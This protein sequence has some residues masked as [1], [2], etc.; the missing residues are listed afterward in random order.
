MRKKYQVVMGQAAE[1]DGQ[2]RRFLL[3]GNNE[4]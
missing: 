4:K 2:S 1:V 3:K